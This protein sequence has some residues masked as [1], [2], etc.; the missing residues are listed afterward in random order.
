MNREVG[1]QDDCVQCAES[2]AAISKAAA[3]NMTTTQET[4]A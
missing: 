1:P 3:Q 4:P 2:R